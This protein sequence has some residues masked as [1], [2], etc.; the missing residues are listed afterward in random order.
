MTTVAM[1]AGMI[2]V[3]LGFH[4]DASFRAPMAVAVIGG[5]LTSTCLTLVVVPAAFT[6]IDDIERWLGPKVGRR[7][8]P[9]DEPPPPAKPHPA[10]DRTRSRLHGSSS[11]SATPAEPTARA[12]RGG[13]GCLSHL[14]FPVLYALASFLALA[15]ATACFRI[16]S[17]WSARTSRRRFRIST[18]RGFGDRCS[19][20]Y[21]GF[22]Q[23]L[24]ELIKAAIAVARARFAAA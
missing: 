2:P 12:R 3:S 22:A 5:L 10:A 11:V 6:L 8:L 17:T 14:P 18:R 1:I 19:D 15:R 9:A 24:V 20:Y 13:C 16:G 21:R 4:G 23:V 7:L